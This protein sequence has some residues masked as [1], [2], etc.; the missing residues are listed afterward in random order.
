MISNFLQILEFSN[1]R[2]KKDFIFF[3]T[4][5][6]FMLLLLDKPEKAVGTF[7]DLP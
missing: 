3:I 2:K 4:L 7:R 1:F 5:N 6:F